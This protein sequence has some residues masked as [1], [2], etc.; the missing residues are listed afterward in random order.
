M[1]VACLGPLGPLVLL[2]WWAQQAL[3]A[4]PALL[5]PPDLRDPQALQETLG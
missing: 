2:A 1:R 5:V 4:Q 3:Q